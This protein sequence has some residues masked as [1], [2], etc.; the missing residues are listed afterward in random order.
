MRLQLASS[1]ISLLWVSLTIIGCGAAS[2]VV[3]GR[4]VR[5]R[6]N[7]T[8]G[9]HIFAVTE[10]YKR[11]L[12]GTPWSDAK[13]Q[14]TTSD[15]RGYF[16]LHTPHSTTRYRM[17]IVISK[18]GYRVWAG[19]LGGDNQYGENMRPGNVFVVKKAASKGQEAVSLGGAR[20]LS[21][22]RV[23]C[24][25]RQNTLCR[26]YRA[27][28]AQRRRY[29]AARA[30]AHPTPKYKWGRTR[31]ESWAKF[32]GDQLVLLDAA[33][34]GGG[35]LAVVE[36]YHLA[37]YYKKYAGGQ[38]WHQGGS[39]SL[40][41]HPEVRRRS[42]LLLLDR[43]NRVVFQ[44]D[45][46]GTR[47]G[48]TLLSKVD[49]HTLAFLTHHGKIRVFDLRT[50]TFT[51]TLQLSVVKA[52]A[53]AF[54]MAPGGGDIVLESGRNT[55]QRYSGKGVWLSAFTVKQ[56]RFIKRLQLGT[57]GACFVHGIAVKGYNYTGVRYGD[58][59]RFGMAL[60]LVKVEKKVGG[61]R[62][63]QLL[64]FADAVDVSGGSI[65]VLR[66]RL[67][68]QRIKALAK[69]EAA[70]LAPSEYERQRLFEYDETGRLKRTLDVTSPVASSVSVKAMSIL[71]GRALLVCP[72]YGTLSILNPPALRSSAG[73][74]SE[75][76][77]VGR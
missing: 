6:I 75:P 73:R 35:L 51:R 10:R 4:S 52:P 57:D 36:S 22:I 37:Y 72:G 54:A 9:F 26:G 43:R 67:V 17:R 28:L 7:D 71:G 5:Y 11:R 58:V 63:R 56:L 32:R 12:F 59:W 8:A 25:K 40:R 76:A 66:R 31:V 41:D 70:A 53:V 50:R 34:V 65:W 29:L 77:S 21:G 18:A 74:R 2:T 16:Q 14:A 42:R 30:R 3:P 60:S 13:Y 45:I 48:R 68:P 27:H 64:T 38:K 23:H 44:R 33:Q 62:A 47:F 69:R 39:W 19:F 1:V 15:A 24:H 20:S 49:D 61:Y 55:L 46:A